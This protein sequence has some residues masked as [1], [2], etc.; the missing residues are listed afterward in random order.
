MSGDAVRTELPL[1]K[2]Q[3]ADQHRPIDL[4]RIQELDGIGGEALYPQPLLGLSES[5]WQR[6]DT[7]TTRIHSGIQ[8]STG[9]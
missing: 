4:E 2:P 9:S 1:A 7:A 6:G 8:W 5:P 3:E